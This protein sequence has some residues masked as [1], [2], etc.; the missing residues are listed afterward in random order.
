MSDDLTRLEDWAEPLLAK[1]QPAARSALAREIALALRRSQSRRIA[2]QQNADGSAYAP[3]K[4]RL[5]EQRG[6]IKRQMF[7][8]LRQ[9]KYL[10]AHSD[11]TRIS[12]GFFDRIANLARVH[13]FGLRDRVDDNGPTVQYERRE[14][15][16]FSREDIEL[17]EGILLKNLAP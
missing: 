11:A 16:G 13:Q 10:K 17:I 9:A 2:A 1:L 5:R 14:L 3:R 7:Q 12:V 6:R 8:K 15:L 4:K